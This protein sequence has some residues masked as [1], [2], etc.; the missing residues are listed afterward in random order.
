VGAAAVRGRAGNHSCSLFKIASKALT[1]S[2]SVSKRR[3]HLF[4]FSLDGTDKNHM[5][6]CRNFRG[7]AFRVQKSGAPEPSCNSQLSR[8]SLYLIENM[9]NVRYKN[10]DVKTFQ[11]KTKLDG[12]ALVF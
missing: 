6:R 4:L 2:I 11:K 5:G 1:A 9:K 3:L 10:A 12:V 8:P 7:D